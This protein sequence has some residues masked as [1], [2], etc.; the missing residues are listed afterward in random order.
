MKEPPLTHKKKSGNDTYSECQSVERGGGGGGGTA[1]TGH[2]NPRP[3][4]KGIPPPKKKD[5]F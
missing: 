5:R 1:A 2:S 4:K 3:I